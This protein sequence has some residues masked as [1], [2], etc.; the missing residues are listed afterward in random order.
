MLVGLVFETDLSTYLEEKTFCKKNN[1]T[2]QVLSL[3][4]HYKHIMYVC[5]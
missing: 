1:Q 3:F 5:D 4:W 2:E